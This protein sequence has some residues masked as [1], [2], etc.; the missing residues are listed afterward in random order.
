MFMLTILALLVIL[1]GFYPVPIMETLNAS[2][3]NLIYNY[4][5]AVKTGGLN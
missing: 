5:I 2:V 1:F 3:D 4:E